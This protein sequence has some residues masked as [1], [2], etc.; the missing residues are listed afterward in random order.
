MAMQVKFPLR[1]LILGLLVAAS[2][3]VGRAA[4]AEKSLPPWAKIQAAVTGHF[5]A[6][7][8]RQPG[9]LIVRSEVE[10]LLARIPGLSLNYQLEVSEKDYMKELTVHCESEE[11]LDAE[12][13]GKLGRTASK[14]LNEGLG[15]RVGF[16]LL[17]PG[18]LERSTGKAV[19]VKKAA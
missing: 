6:M 13:A 18:I 9:D 8:D 7:A 15:I 10:A 12:V 5:A 11:L 1:Y 19:R 16:N 17:V 2:H 4:P 14:K 3:D